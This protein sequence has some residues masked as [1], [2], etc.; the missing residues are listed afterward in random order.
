MLEEGSGMS[1]LLVFLPGVC[2]P[3]EGKH[4]SWTPVSAS[5][6]EAAPASAV[7]PSGIWAGVCSGAG[8]GR[9]PEGLCS[10]GSLQ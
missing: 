4:S 10:L 3:S 1:T 2:L 7:S 5:G 8:G 6:E 9:P